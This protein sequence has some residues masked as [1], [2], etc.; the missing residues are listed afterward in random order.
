MSVLGKL[1]KL[2]GEVTN[3]NDEEKEH[4]TDREERRL[5]DGTYKPLPGWLTKMDF[6][7]HSRLPGIQFPHMS[8]TVKGAIAFTKN[9]AEGAQD[10]QVYMLVKE[11]LDT[12]FGYTISFDLKTRIIKMLEAEQIKE[13][14][15]LKILMEVLNLRKAIGE[16]IWGLFPQHDFFVLLRTLKESADKASKDA[17]EYPNLFIRHGV[18]QAINKKLSEGEQLFVA[19]ENETL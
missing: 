7:K 3:K 5:R 12:Y 17:F 10:K 11:Y 13:E 4:W 18:L 1:V 16:Q 6:W 8:I 14:R 2:Y 9:A 19:P 15:E